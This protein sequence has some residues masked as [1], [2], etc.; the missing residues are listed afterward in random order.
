MTGCDLR[1]LAEQMGGR[2]ADAH[3][4]NVYTLQE[5]REDVANV[6]ASVSALAESVAALTS[7][8]LRLEASEGQEA[9]TA[10]NDVNDT[11]EKVREHFHEAVDQ[12]VSDGGYYDEDS[13][14][15]AVS[16]A[17]RSLRRNIA[18][19]IQDA[20]SDIDVDGICRHA[21]AD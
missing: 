18:S 3:Q 13:M 11:I 4:A 5:I 14:S 15:E 2:R 21:E 17:L 10:R 1:Y 12:R 19:A 6:A 8:L 16:E 7:R 20:L 9:E